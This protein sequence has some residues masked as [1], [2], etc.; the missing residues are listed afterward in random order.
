VTKREVMD[1]SPSLV[2][3]LARST[4]EFTVEEITD[5]ISDVILDRKGA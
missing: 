1:Y 5:E 3:K 4:T 2:D